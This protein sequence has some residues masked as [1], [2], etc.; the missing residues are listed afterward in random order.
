MPCL[1]Q[2]TASVSI[3]V[4]AN[5]HAPPHFHIVTPDGDALVAIISLQIIRGQVR[6]QAYAA[7]VTWASDPANRAALVAEWKRLNVDD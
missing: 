6:R 7:A 1:V 3:Y 4:Y 5:D 2:L